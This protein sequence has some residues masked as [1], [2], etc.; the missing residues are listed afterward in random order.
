MKEYYVQVTYTHHANQ[1]ITNTSIYIA[2]MAHQEHGLRPKHYVFKNSAEISVQLPNLSP[3]LY[4][5]LKLAP[6][7]RALHWNYCL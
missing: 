5:G 4:S 6:V 1:I 7:C 2:K 3:D